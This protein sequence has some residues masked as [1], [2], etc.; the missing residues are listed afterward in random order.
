MGWLEAQLLASSPVPVSQGTW[1]RFID[2]IFLLWTGTPQNLDVFFEHVKST[3]ASSTDQLPFLIRLKDGF[4]KKDTHTNPQIAT[5]TSPTAH[6][7][8]AMLSRTS[9]TASSWAYGGSARTRKCSTSAVTKGKGSSC[10][11]A[12]T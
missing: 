3:I 1:K 9:P 2:D 6:V 4:L 11:G 10:V 7:T 12:I 8:P 5:P